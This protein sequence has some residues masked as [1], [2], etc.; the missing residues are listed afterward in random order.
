MALTL[1]ALVVLSRAGLVLPA[2]H[3]ASRWLVW[4]V[5]AVMG[6]GGVMN[7]LTPSKGERLIWAPVATLLFLA[8][9]VVGLSP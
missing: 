4:I 5:V 1:L 7:L 6:A 9:L 8:A 3:G 2:W